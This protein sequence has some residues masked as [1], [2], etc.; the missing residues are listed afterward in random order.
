MTSACYKEGERPL[1]LIETGLECPTC[2]SH[3]TPVPRGHLCFVDEV[4]EN[5][6]LKGGG[7]W[8][9]VGGLKQGTHCKDGLSV[10]V[11]LIFFPSVDWREIM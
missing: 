5:S 9:G 7:G 1:I 8:V 10:R 6:F 3:S 4:F 11:P 2:F